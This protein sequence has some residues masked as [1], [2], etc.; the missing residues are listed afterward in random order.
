MYLPVIY[1]ERFLIMTNF[2][3]FLRWR[4]II[5]AEMCKVFIKVWCWFDDA[6]VTFCLIKSNEIKEKSKWCAE[7]ENSCETSEKQVHGCTALKMTIKF[8]FSLFFLVQRK[9][10]F[11]NFTSCS[12]KSGDKYNWIL[13]NNSPNEGYN[14]AAVK[15]DLL[16]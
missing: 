9:L 13:N 3:Q 7:Y 10:C 2:H 4:R 6:N 14:K 15:R 5:T 1:S 11:I 12:L 8:K 16:H